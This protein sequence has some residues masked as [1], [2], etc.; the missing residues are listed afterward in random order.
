MVRIEC[1]LL[2]GVFG[3]TET[4]GTETRGHHQETCDSRQSLPGRTS[5]PCPQITS[6]ESRK[7]PAGQHRERECC[8]RTRHRSRRRRSSRKTIRPITT[9]MGDPVVPQ[10][11]LLKG[12]E[13]QASL[14][15]PA[16]HVRLHD[17]RHSSC[18]PHVAAGQ[19]ASPEAS[20]SVF[21]SGLRVSVLKIRQNA[22][23]MASL[24][25]RKAENV[26]SAEHSEDH[27]AQ[28]ADVEIPSV[29]TPGTC[30]HG[31]QVQPGWL[32]R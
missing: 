31:E 5:A 1:P 13:G 16:F 4:G 24:Q 29:S 27:Q 10:A 21:L 28:D 11:Q 32:S 17:E 26:L 8:Q 14:V 22:Y 19:L 12:K 20:D 9:Q 23:A 7:D 18:P 25:E 30:K 3:T 15:T 2:R 6:R